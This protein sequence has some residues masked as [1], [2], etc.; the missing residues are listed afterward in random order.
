MA[1]VLF[2]NGSGFESSS[3]PYEVVAGVIV[4]DRDLWNFVQAI[5]DAKVRHFGATAPTERLTARR[6]L[7]RKVFRL[8]HQLPPLPFEERRALARACL[9]RGAAA[10]K[11]EM[12]ALAQSKVAYVGEVFE[13][14]SRFRC[15]LIASIVSNRLP[16]PTPGYLRKDYAFLLERF[17]YFLEDQKPP[18]CGF[19][20]CR[21]HAA[22]FSEL[23]A[24]QMA[25][26][27]KG[28]VRG[29][30]RTSLVLP[31]PLAVRGDLAVGT[32]VAAL[33]AYVAAWGFRTRELT[34]PARNEL[35]DFKEQIRA[36]RYRAVREIGDSTN[37]VIW[38]FTVVNDLRTREEREQ[39]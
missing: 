24:D 15:R 19:V 12:T 7:K 23:L 8:A 5:L 3:S 16:R 32:E 18:Q 27:F 14:C 9:E 20:A 17:Y 34:E 4:E 22:P 33:V 29:R 25:R 35:Y 39:G 11:R 26:Y 10:G 30:Q 38:G 2:V 36:L 28:T 1:W 37:F 21:E 6:L 31:D 13:V